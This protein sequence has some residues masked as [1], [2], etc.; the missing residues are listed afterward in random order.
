MIAYDQ[1]GPSELV[2]DGISGFLVPPQDVNALTEALLHVDE[3]DRCNV[4]K[5]A[6][7]FSLDRFADRCERFIEHV[8]CGDC[9]GEVEWEMQASHPHY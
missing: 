1:G 8:I 2:Q 5:R 9:S 3:L 6:E 7:E 4:R